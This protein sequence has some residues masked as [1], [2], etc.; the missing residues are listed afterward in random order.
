MLFIIIWIL[1]LIA[2]MILKKN[3]LIGFFSILLSILFIINIPLDTVQDT[4]VYYSSYYNDNG[5]F[6][7]GYSEI[8]HWFLTNG[9][10]FWQFKFVVSFI[11]LLLI[12]FSVQKYIQN[13][14]L[15]V[16]LWLPFPF[17]ID[18][19]QF[20][21]FLMMSLVL[22]S[23]IYILK[24]NILSK[25]YGVFVL[26]AATLFHSGAWI[27]F[28]VIPLSFF[29]ISKIIKLVPVMI[30]FSWVLGF[31]LYFTPLAS[32]LITLLSKYIMSVTNR[33]ALA[34]RVGGIYVPRF[35]QIF[36]F[37]VAI[38]IFVL[39]V[40]KIVSRGIDMQENLNILKP[41]LLF[42]V[43]SLLVIPLVTM[44]WDYTRIMRNSFI[45]AE[46]AYIWKI[47]HSL[48][49]SNRKKTPTIS[50]TAI[51]FTVSYLIQAVVIYYPA[52]VEHIYRIINM[53]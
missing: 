36:L 46:I 32:K 6:E 7:Y 42:S 40:T 52:E 41:L 20:R 26:Y 33:E 29:K 45:F 35:W 17:L 50:F 23:S 37:W 12:G 2:V 10:S 39:I 4:L 21:N 18:V 49:N 16:L 51:M 47:E 22:Y 14:S 27:F 25:S 1:N 30:M 43:V 9:Y 38:T 15:F 28:L 19:I 53:N 8:S 24:S 11:A 13:I 31:L 44:Q 5:G 34:D 3:R 48:S